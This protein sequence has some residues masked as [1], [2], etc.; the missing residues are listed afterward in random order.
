MSALEELNKLPV[1]EN[2]PAPVSKVEARKQARQKM[3]EKEYKELE[4]RQREKG[5]IA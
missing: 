1:P 4:Q 2:I 5:N 3:N